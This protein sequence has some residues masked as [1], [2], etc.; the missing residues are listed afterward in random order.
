MNDTRSAARIWSMSTLRQQ[1]SELRVHG[2]A[3]F[4]G[5]VTGVSAIRRAVHRYKDGRILEEQKV[6]RIALQAKQLAEK[7]DLAERQA[8]P[9]RTLDRKLR[10]LKKVEDREI[11]A[12]KRDGLKNQRVQEREG[13]DGMPPLDI[14]RS[15][16]VDKPLRPEFEAAKERGAQAPPD[17]VRDFNGAA[18][19]RQPERS[20][21][22]GRAKTPENGPE[23]ER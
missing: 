13:F 12:L 5:R 3:G 15:E 8:L 16:I 22:A 4:L 14:A 18:C 1:R 2:L 10:S 7:K 17:P 6:Q 23:R 11:A 20:D 19:T 9:S 21:D